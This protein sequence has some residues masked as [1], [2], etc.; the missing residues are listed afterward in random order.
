VKLRMPAIG[1]RNISVASSLIPVAA[2]LAL[3]PILTRSLGATGFGLWATLFAILGSVQLVDFGV[4]SSLLR[5][6]AVAQSQEGRTG[7]KRYLG[8]AWLYYLVLAACSFI[9]VL[10]WHQQLY[11]F[12]AVRTT[13]PTLTIVL[14]FSLVALM[15]ISN[16]SVVALQSVGDFK[17][18][19]G[20][21]LCSQLVYA[22]GIVLGSIFLNFTVATVLIAQVCQVSIVFAYVTG[23]LRMHHVGHLLTRTEF[24]QFGRFSGRVWL[25]NLSSVAVLQLPVIIVATKVSPAQAGVYGLAAMVSLG[26][27][28]IPLTS[29]A[30]IVRSLTGTVEEIVS[31][32]QVA[33]RTWRRHLLVYAGVGTVGIV[34]G[35]PVLGGPGYGRAIGP[36]VLLFAGYVIQLWGALATITS[37]QLELTK[38]EWRATFLGAGIHLALL[39]FAISALGLYGPGIVLIISQSVTLFFVR[40]QFRSFSHH[41]TPVSHIR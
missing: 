23:H 5:F 9:L 29:L 41:P 4:G 18:M 6:M 35:V 24:E 36:C 25:T 3:T 7:S 28:N 13:S 12:V 20:I 2:A 8:A 10:P 31:R 37:R 26:L 32:S 15:P 38:V 19:A 21:V 16:A 33:D 27:R 39:W 17:H 30:P 34:L 40:R 1:D 22:L 14:F 11:A